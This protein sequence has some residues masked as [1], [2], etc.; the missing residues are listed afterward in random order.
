[1]FQR[2]KWCL[3]QIMTIQQTKGYKTNIVQTRSKSCLETL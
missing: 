3:Q 1:M 2:N